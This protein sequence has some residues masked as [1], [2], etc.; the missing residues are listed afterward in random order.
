L[1]IGFNLKATKIKTANNPFRRQTVDTVKNIVLV[2]FESHA[3]ISLSLVVASPVA[4]EMNDYDII[5]A[6]FP[7]T[8]LAG[9]EIWHEQ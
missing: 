7:G 4:A 2:N 6:H 3:G 8:I 5:I 1:R 9:R